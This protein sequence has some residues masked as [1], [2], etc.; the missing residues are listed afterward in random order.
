MSARTAT[1][2]RREFME[3][4]R[5][6]AYLV[7]TVVGPLLLF[8]VMVVPALV[9]SRQRTKALKVAVL[10]ETG[11]LRAEV[12]ASLGR[13]KVRDEARFLVQ[14]APAGGRAVAEKDVVAGRLDGYVYLPA[15]AIERSVAEYHA[16][17][18]ADRADVQLVDT[19]VEDAVIGLRLR[20]AGLDPARVEGLTRRID[21]KSV[22]LSASGAREDRGA[23]LI[24]S[25][26]LMMLLYTTVAMWG[27]A[28]MNGVI[29]EKTSRVVEVI[30]SSVPTTSLFLGKLLGVGAAGLVQFLV[31]TA[32]LALASLYGG[33]MALGRA[34]SLPELGPTLLVAFVLYFVLGFFLYGSL[35]AA[36]GSAVNNAQEAQSLSF[37][38][39]LPL[40]LAAA[41]SPVVIRAPESPLA[42]VL[43]LVP[44]FAPLHMVLRI[45][46]VTPPLWQ[47]GLSMALMVA[48]I[49]AITWAAARVYRTGILMYGK[50]A[51]FPEIVRWVRAG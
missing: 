17:N 5:S 42:V 15:D 22:R 30:V 11:R 45:S 4:V 14:P 2:V 23:T 41:F 6:R 16:R 32:S 8:G 35:F 25:M 46:S 24:A 1:V 31:W 21:L 48:T 19:A 50:R 28:I 29:E 43:S 27:A 36:V 34:G 47:V 7:S 13:R 18:V 3:R 49:G 20:E 12:E 10:D 9:A 44:F 33:G 39:F 40:I 37:P 51:T 38:A 26:L